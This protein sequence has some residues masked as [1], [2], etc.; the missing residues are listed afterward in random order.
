MTFL[1]GVLWVLRVGVGFGEGVPVSLCL[2][3]CPSPETNFMYAISDNYCS[4][5]T[6]TTS[7]SEIPW[8]MV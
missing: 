4:D 8:Y 2:C 3:L 5:W 1:G 6:L 7:N